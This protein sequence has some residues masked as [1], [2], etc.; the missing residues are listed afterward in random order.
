MFTSRRV[1]RSDVYPDSQFPLGL[2]LSGT[3]FDLL[4]SFR[5]VLMV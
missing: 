5:I 1:I 2:G 3:P 4:D